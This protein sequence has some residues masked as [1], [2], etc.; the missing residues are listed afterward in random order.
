M[1]WKAIQGYEGYYEISDTG[2]IRSLDRVVPDTKT[3][4]KCLKGKLMKQTESIGKAR[5]DGY[6]VVNLRK[7]HTGNVCQVHRLVAE[8]FI[9]NPLG[10]PT[11]NHKDGNKHNNNVTNLEWASY[12]ENNIHALENG[13]RSPRGTYIRQRSLDG[14]LISE[15]RSVCE[16]S[17]ITGIG[18]S[19]ISHCVN[20]R[21]KSAGGFL[22]SKMDK[23][24]D[25]LKDESTAEDELP[26]EVL[27][28]GSP[29]R[30]S[31]AQMETSE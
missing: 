23:C 17:R 15:F 12:S 8:A 10:L 25:Y 16:A 2:L 20:G 1:I 19:M 27:G 26:L 9:E 3:G 29:R 7:N 18:R 22:W 5:E 31:L 13:L 6:Y 21:V 4:S 14:S 28:L 30:Y 24:N 11:V